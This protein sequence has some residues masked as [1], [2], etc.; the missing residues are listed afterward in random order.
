MSVLREISFTEAELA[1]EQDAALN[2][3]I[4]IQHREMRKLIEEQDI[5]LIVLAERQVKELMD[6][7]RGQR[8]TARRIT[9]SRPLTSNRCIDELADRMADTLLELT[10]ESDPARKGYWRYR[11]GEA[12]WLGL[13]LVAAKAALLRKGMCG[14]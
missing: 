4:Q 10:Y 12:I 14:K 8:Q 3:F 7:E 9:H 6:F 11:D 2:E 5:A 1:E 13:D